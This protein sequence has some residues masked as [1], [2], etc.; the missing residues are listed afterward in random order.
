[1]QKHDGG[2]MVLRRTWWNAQMHKSIDHLAEGKSPAEF[3]ATRKAN[4]SI[5]EEKI[6]QN[7]TS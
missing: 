5:G 2:E 1:M 3:L 4:T 6:N 7:E